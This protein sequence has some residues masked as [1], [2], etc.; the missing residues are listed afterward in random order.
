MDRSDTGIESLLFLFDNRILFVV[1]VVVVVVVQIPEIAAVMDGRE[2][3][4]LAEVV[5]LLLAPGPAIDTVYLEEKLLIESENDVVEDARQLFA[6]ARQHAYSL[7][8]EAFELRQF[9]LE[10]DSLIN[11]TRKEAFEMLRRGGTMDRDV[12]R[13]SEGESLALRSR[14]GMPLSVGVQAPRLFDLQEE[15]DA[16][17]PPRSYSDVLGD[18]RH[19]LLQQSGNSR[20]AAGTDDLVA[21]DAEKTSRPS[22]VRRSEHADATTGASAV[23]TDST[24]KKAGEM[25]SLKVVGSGIQQ[26]A[27]GVLVEWVMEEER[28]AL[29]TYDHARASLLAMKAEAAKQLMLRAASRVL[30][31]L[32]RVVWQLCTAQK[33]PFVQ[34]SLKGIVFDR[35]RNRDHSGSA[36]FLIHRIEILDATGMLPEGPATP[37]GVI[38][39]VWNPDSTYERDPILRI[40]ATMG[41]PT[42]T[43][44]VFQHLDATLHP[45]SVHLTESIAVACW[46]YFFPKEDS[47]T[48][49]EQFAQSVSLPSHRGK[50][51][52]PSEAAASSSQPALADITS[53][54]SKRATAES[55]ATPTKLRH[56]GGSG[57]MALAMSTVGSTAESAANTPSSVA[58]Q[59]QQMHQFVRESSDLH[60]S[61]HYSTIKTESFKSVA[62]T[63]SRSEVQTRKRKR[64]V[65]VK[66]NRAHLRITYQGYPMYVVVCVGS[67]A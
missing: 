54:S 59:R 4:V 31:K 11:L 18:L 6:L 43:Y 45:L 51:S 62:S 63:H 60:S 42:A 32:D 3:E 44:T 29:E 41:I 66:L 50:R 67:L 10:D 16:S 8:H 1:V 9:L 37:P 27:F 49:Q 23:H 47:K 39:T 52:M 34:T 46:E 19:V 22:A 28:Q 7:R 56:A 20:S 14:E 36:K 35:H 24:D 26:K 21:S 33:Q 12:A 53:S 38:L 2:F 61:K 40:V 57:D 17:S 64:F 15:R 30:L 5:S 25:S 58:A 65:Y 48:R 55:Q 13:E